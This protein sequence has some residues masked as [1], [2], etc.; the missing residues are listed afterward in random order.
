MIGPSFFNVA[1]A[2]GLSNPIYFRDNFYYIDGTYST[3]HELRHHKNRR[4]YS[5]WPM[6][7]AYNKRKINLTVPL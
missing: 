5:H 1:I 6:T 7:M 4:V 2:I 3:F